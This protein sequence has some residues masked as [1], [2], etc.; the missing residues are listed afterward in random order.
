MYAIRSYYGAADYMIEFKPHGNEEYDAKILTQRDKVRDGRR[1]QTFDVL[2]TPKHEGL[3]SVGLETL[4]RHV[5]TSYSIHYTKLYEICSV[6]RK[7][8]SHG[9]LP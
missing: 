2:I 3:I 6:G 5:I 4:I 9:A 8:G 7:V 1:I